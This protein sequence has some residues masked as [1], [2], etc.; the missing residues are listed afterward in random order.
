MSGGK[1]N[2]ARRRHA[3]IR[4][5]KMNIEDI[6]RD[7]IRYLMSDEYLRDRVDT[8]NFIGFRHD[9]EKAR[10]ALAQ[11]EEESAKAARRK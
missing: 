7:V 11:L 5:T 4:T 3:D 10:K 2:R 9:L 8:C 6:E 1:Q